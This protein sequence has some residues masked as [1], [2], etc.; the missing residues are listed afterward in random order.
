LDVVD[1]RLTLAVEGF[2]G[3]R[4][5]ISGEWP[6]IRVPAPGHLAWTVEGLKPESAVSVRWVESEGRP[7]FPVRETGSSGRITVDSVTEGPVQRAL[8][9]EGITGDGRS[10]ALAIPVAVIA[11][12][13]RSNGILDIAI[14]PGDVSLGET[15]SATLT[16]SMLLV[17]GSDASVAWR[18]EDPSVLTLSRTDADEVR[19]EGRNAGVTSVQVVSVANPLVRD[20]VEVTVTPEP[21][22]E[23]VT[24]SP[25]DVTVT[26]GDS[27][28]LD[29]IVT[30][31]HVSADVQWSSSDPSVATVDANGLV[32]FHVNDA[33]VQIA[34]ASVADSTRKDTVTVTASVEP[35]LDHAIRPDTRGGRGI[36]CGGGDDAR[37]RRP[38]HRR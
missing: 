5:A 30:A 31:F 7:A 25:G 33:S 15:E 3:E 1:V 10:F 9:V 20:A 38:I 21:R 14:S 27:T 37:W 34:A 35:F 29:A 11:L 12:G 13:E 26:A 2:D 28:D 8:V 16:A 36:R 22:V 18:V 19:I 24:I 4:Y 23:S 6:R 32:T 17:S